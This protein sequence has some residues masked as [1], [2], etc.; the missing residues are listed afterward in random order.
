MD[1]LQIESMEEGVVFTVK[2]VPGSSKTSVCGLLDGMLKIKVSA[3]PQ[4]GKANRCLLEFLAKQLAVKKNTVSV[5]TGQTG[6]VKS[7]RVLG[8][9]ADTLLEK[10]N[11]NR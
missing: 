8:I 2:V 5:I 6:P 7:V 3:A 9:S 10:L 1:K 4:K 11:L